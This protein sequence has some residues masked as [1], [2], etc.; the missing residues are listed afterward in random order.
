ML[1]DTVLFDVNANL[2][3]R[4]ATYLRQ[5]GMFHSSFVG[6]SVLNAAAKET[7]W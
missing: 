4:V 7:N 6:S 1:T 5:V 2:R 3:G